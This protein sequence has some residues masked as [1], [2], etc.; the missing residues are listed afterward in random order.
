MAQER[1]RVSSG[2]PTV[3]NRVRQWRVRQVQ[4]TPSRGKAIELDPS[5]FRVVNA[6]IQKGANTAAHV[7]WERMERFF[8][9]VQKEWPHPGHDTSGKSTGY[10][11]SRLGLKMVQQGDTLMVSVSNDADYALY[12]VQNR[13]N[14]RHTFR[15][16]IFHPADGVAEELVELIG[17]ALA[18]PNPGEVL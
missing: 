16:I 5:V 9:E 17:D 4:G 3:S 10:S 14:P 12:I 1:R 2:R 11:R 15:R 18:S 7:F 13:F 8:D 6:L